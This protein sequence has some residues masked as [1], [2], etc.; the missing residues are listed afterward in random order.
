MNNI[1]DTLQTLREAGVLTRVAT[2]RFPGSSGGVR[3]SREE[4]ERVDEAWHQACISESTERLMRIV[5]DCG[6][7]EAK[8]K[9]EADRIGLG[10]TTILRRVE[11]GLGRLQRYLS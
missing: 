7:N 11:E 8:L 2:V 1:A 6:D 10:Q 3:I 4:K 5:V 9:T